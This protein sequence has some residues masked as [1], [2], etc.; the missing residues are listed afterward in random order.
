MKI[1]GVCPKCG[2]SDIIADAKA[3]DRGDN[4]SQNELSLGM[5]RHPNNF[6]FKGQER[7]TVSAWACVGCGF[8]EFY[9]D[10]AKNLKI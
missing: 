7:T 9:A 2:S 8:I 6:I 4:H 5:Y 3:I 10:E 1:N